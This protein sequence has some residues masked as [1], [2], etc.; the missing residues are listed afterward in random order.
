MAASH[1]HPESHPPPPDRG[2]VGEGRWLA[3]VLVA[4]LSVEW[5]AFSSTELTIAESLL[6][7]EQERLTA[8]GIE[9]GDSAVALARVELARE[10]A[11]RIHVT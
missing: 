10:R 5:S 1:P 4:G 11:R 2:S 7:E 6:I 8:R 3:R 9:C